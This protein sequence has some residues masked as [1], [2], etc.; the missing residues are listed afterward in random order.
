MGLKI[1]LVCWTFSQASE[2]PKRL[3]CGISQAS[4]KEDIA[5]ADGAPRDPVAESQQKALPRG[6]PVFGDFFCGSHKGK[7]SR[8]W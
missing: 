4:G 3:F 2:I 1:P 6:L 8:S 5:D 7:R